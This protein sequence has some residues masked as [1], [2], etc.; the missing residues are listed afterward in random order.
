[1]T[2]EE[3]VNNA[4][5]QTRSTHIYTASFE[6]HSF[7][8]AMTNLEKS[9]EDDKVICCSFFLPRQ[10]EGQTKAHETS[11]KFLDVF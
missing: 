11:P 3:E 9:I 7:F 1:M 2:E 4:N 6:R 5:R 10:K 8:V